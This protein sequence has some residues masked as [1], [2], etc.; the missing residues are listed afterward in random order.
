LDGSVGVAENG[1]LNLRSKADGF[2]RRIDIGVQFGPRAVHAGV[3]DP[4]HLFVSAEEVKDLMVLDPILCVGQFPTELVTADIGS[5]KIFADLDK[6][7]KI[8]L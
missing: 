6:V 1:Q 4:Q 5:Q 2:H 7:R 3:V 8:S